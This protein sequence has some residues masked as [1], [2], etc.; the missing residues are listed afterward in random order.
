M[1]PELDRVEA[2][3]EAAKEEGARAVY[4]LG[5]GG[6]SLCAEVL[7]QVCG[8]A[9]GH[10]DLLVLDTTDER[11]IAGAAAAME[12]GRTIVLV[13]SKSGGTVEVAS[14]ERFFWQL[15]QGALGPDAGRR[16]VAVTDPGTALHA[17]A[18]ARAAT[19]RS[20]STRPTSAGASRRCRS[21]ASSPRRS[22]AWTCA[23]CTR[24]V[25]R[26]PRAAARRTTR[27]RA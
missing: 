3:G 14:M 10:P 27:T 19:A 12:P 23:S 15:L 26:W 5:M 8:V 7:K 11:T 9:E 2:L 18:Q 1:A 16:F 22:S 20:S 17:L 6:S 13:A 4:L 21:S 24:P 25:R